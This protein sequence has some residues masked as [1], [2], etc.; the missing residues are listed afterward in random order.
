[1]R[2]IKFKLTISL[3]ISLAAALLTAPALA[4]GGQDERA[5]LSALVASLDARHAG[6]SIQ[7]AETAEAALQES[8]VAQNRLQTWYAQAERACLEVFFVNACLNEIK[9]QRRR[10]QGVLQRITI[11]AKALQRKLH[12]QQLDQS[13]QQKHSEK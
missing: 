6:G 11:E 2:L 9:L 10:H 4:Q 5:V 12:I 3:V 13:L 8:A 1:M 7:T